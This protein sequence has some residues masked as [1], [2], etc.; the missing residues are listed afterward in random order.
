[1]AQFVQI[2]QEPDGDSG[3]ETVVEQWDMQFDGVPPTH[4]LRTV[5]YDDEPTKIY[6]RMVC[7]LTLNAPWF[8]CHRLCIPKDYVLLDIPFGRS[9]NKIVFAV[10]CVMAR[11]LYSYVRVLPAYRLYR[12]C[13]D[14]QGA[15]NNLT[16]RLLHKSAPMLQP[17][18]AEGR[19][20]GGPKCTHVER[21]AFS[22]IETMT[23]SLQ[24]SVQYHPQVAPLASATAVPVSIPQHVITDY[25]RPP[26]AP[27]LSVPRKNGLALNNSSL[28]NALLFS[29]LPPARGDM[30]GCCGCCRLRRAEGSQDAQNVSISCSISH[31]T[32]VTGGG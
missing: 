1:M 25:I 32:S 26:S 5:S 29:W 12:A 21:F 17:V 27:L 7:L 13:R 3:R 23:G 11:T 16:Y 18:G 28:R 20:D 15:A 6:K 8:V 19:A 2:L 10:Q 30:A 31:C 14:T 24:I 4:H 9:I 22:P